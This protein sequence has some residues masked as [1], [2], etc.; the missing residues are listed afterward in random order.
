MRTH[1][2]LISYN[3]DQIRADTLLDISEQCLKCIYLNDNLFTCKAFQKG[4]PEEI[5]S[6]KFEHTKHYKGDNN[7]VFHPENS[8]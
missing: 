8:S 4:I 6:G 7:I 1:T 2:I 5:L 3:D